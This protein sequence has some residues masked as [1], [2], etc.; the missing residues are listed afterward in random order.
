[1]KKN[2]SRKNNNQ[3]PTLQDW[4][5]LILPETKKTSSI[6]AQEILIN[7]RYGNTKCS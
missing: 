1:M 7:L 3:K 4:K 5:K 6:D 2:T